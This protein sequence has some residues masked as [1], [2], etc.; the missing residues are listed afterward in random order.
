MGFGED[1]SR[2]KTSVPA[3]CS[4]LSGAGGELEVRFSVSI[5]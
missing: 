1:R 4:G 3:P 2:K 5:D